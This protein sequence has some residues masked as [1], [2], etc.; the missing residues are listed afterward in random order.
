MS[1]FLSYHLDYLLSIT[2]WDRVRV[3]DISLNEEEPS[4]RELGSL[5][6]TGT[7]GLE[8]RDGVLSMSG[9]RLFNFLQSGENSV[10][11][12]HQC[13]NRVVPKNLRVF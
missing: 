1:T 7:I 13:P 8:M 4:F 6:L 5:T 11:R 10:L 2:I 12:H 9:D 3:H